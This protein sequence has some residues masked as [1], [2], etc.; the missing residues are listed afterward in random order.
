MAKIEAIWLDEYGK[1][2]VETY[3]KLKERIIASGAVI[4]TTLP[5]KDKEKGM[6]V[7]ELLEDPEIG[8]MVEEIEW[9]A[10]LL[11]GEYPIASL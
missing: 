9:L 10:S 1:A 5:R 7:E 2:T 6:T 3:N 4:F 8:E 11:E